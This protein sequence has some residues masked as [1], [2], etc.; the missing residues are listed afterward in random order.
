MAFIL[1]QYQPESRAIFLF[2]G[3]GSN[4]I[5]PIR[6]IILFIKKSGLTLETKIKIF[7]QSWVEELKVYDCLFRRR[8]N[9]GPP[10]RETNKEPLVSFAGIVSRFMTFI[11]PTSS[12]R[13]KIVWPP[14]TQERPWEIILLNYGVRGRSAWPLIWSAQKL[15][16]VSLL[17]F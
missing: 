1:R 12:K 6:F 14:L 3:D 16:V 10:G 7:D 4:H 13:N 8:S 9:S 17:K 2:R 5:F 11:E 15:F